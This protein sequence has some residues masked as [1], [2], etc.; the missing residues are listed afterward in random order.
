MATGVSV[1]K[2]IGGPALVSYRGATFYA[3]S[4]ITLELAQQTFPVSVDAYREVD[5]RV[6]RQ[7]IRVRFIPAGEWESLTVLYDYDNSP[8]GD[9][10][11]PNR[12]LGVI[13]SNRITCYSHLLL[14]G[15]L[16]YVTNS[17]GALP[18]GLSAGTPYYIRSYS[19][20][21]LTFHL[22]LADANAGTNIIAISGGTGTNKLVVNNPL[23]IQTFAGILI[24]LWNAAITKIPDIV[25]SATETL[26]EEVQFDAFLGDG[27]DPTSVIAYY[28]I[29]ASPYLGDTTFN[30]A[31]ILTQPVNIAWGTSPWDSFQ[32]KTGVRVRFDLS[33]EDVDI[34]GLG[35]L[36]KRISGLKVTA[37]GIPV[38]ISESDLLTALQQQGAGAGI[39]RSLG[40]GK[41]DFVMS[42]TGFYA[43][44]TAAA[45]VGGPQ[46]F[47]SRQDRV[48]ELTWVA[49][50]TFTNGMPNALFYIGTAVPS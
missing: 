21:A 45:L 49:T 22:T 38:G 8:L 24:T 16:V 7:P 15:D 43:K 27:R 9:L 1:T 32:M 2:I 50:R 18:S 5:E 25:G 23:T 6:R 28:S 47:S 35:T 42:A 34:D 3:K 26:L 14:T 40:S 4:D 20:D 10:I 37:R 33:L 46:L 41:A 39:G 44:L 29:A 30:P 11:T 17:G 12:T 36:T 19:S 48:G 13:V 31:N